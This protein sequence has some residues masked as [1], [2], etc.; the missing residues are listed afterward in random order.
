VRLC[1]MALTD[2]TA[3]DDDAPKIATAH[4]GSLLLSRR[5]LAMTFGSIALFLPLL[6]Q[7]LDLTFSLTATSTLLAVVPSTG[8]VIVIFAIH[9]SFV[10][11]YF[12]SIF[13]LPIQL[14]RVRAEG[15]ATGFGNFFAN[16]GAFTAS[17]WGR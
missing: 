3:S 4:V 12:G 13:A 16:M 11:V 17:R 1:W 10:Q 14:L 9:T 15:L 8:V 6:R 5:L 7:E 2:Q